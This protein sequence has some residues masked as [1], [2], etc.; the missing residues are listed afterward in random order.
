MPTNK[1]Q[2]FV[3]K[4]LLRPFCHGTEERSIN[5]LNLESKKVILSAS[6]SDQCSKTYFYGTDQKL[7]SAIQS[8]EQ[9]Y[10]IIRKNV[11]ERAISIQ[12]RD[13]VLGLKR[14]ALFQSMRTLAAVK[15]ATQSLQLMREGVNSDPRAEV[16]DL[17]DQKTITQFA[18]HAFVENMPMLDDLAVCLIENRTTGEFVI[19]DDPVVHINRWQFE[20]RKRSGFG[21]GHAGTTIF[22]PIS[23]QIQLC[24][25]DSGIYNVK[26]NGLW[27]S[28]DESSDVELLNQLQISNSLSNIYF[29][30]LKG[31]GEL[32]GQVE[33]NLLQWPKQIWSSGLNVA[34]L[35]SESEDHKEYVALTGGST[36][37][38]DEQL[39]HVWK[40][41]SPI[42][43]WP[44]FVK[45]RRNQKF[46][47]TGTGRGAI[48]RH[49]HKWHS[50]TD[51]VV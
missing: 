49:T 29:S 34:E 5:L 8:L 13:S 41:F 27:L 20:R 4:V 12:D 23:P 26:R 45:Y 31:S 42:P 9:H 19:G 22:M 17:P 35:A 36:P 15:E 6:V 48:R 30:D 32:L 24:L 40:Q 37:S 33:R 43:A 44:S 10:G 16:P 21:P 18:M 3:P 14:F 46:V 2:H 39:V 1:N 47:D 51:W 38:A 50:G 11:T 25:Y 28:L 7:E